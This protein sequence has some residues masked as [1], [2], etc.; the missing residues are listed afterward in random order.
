VIKKAAS[1]DYGKRVFLE[2]AT[3]VVFS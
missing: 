2:I 3:L 1:T